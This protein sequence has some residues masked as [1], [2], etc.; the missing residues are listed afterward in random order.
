MNDMAGNFLLEVALRS[1]IMF[2]TLL[3]VLKF[4]GKRGIKQLSIFELVIII[5]LGSAAGDPM[6]Y[7][8]VGI[9]HG[10][11]VLLVVLLLYR[12]LTWITGKSPRLERLLEGDPECLLQD[13]KLTEQQFAHDNL[14]RDE[15]FSVL[16]V[17]GVEHLG[18]VREAYLETSGDISVFFYPD[19]QVKPGL[20]ILPHALKHT[21]TLIS[22]ASQY[23]CCRCGEVT[24]LAF[25]SH[26]CNTCNGN[27]WILPV[28]SKRIT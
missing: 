13:G 17:R 23:C 10:I 3:I 14:G 21:Q 18:Q 12:A 27:S 11:I 9:V 25:G 20:P 26:T 2:I 16:R 28:S 7:E 6:F 19:E 24:P 22:E 8:D 5:S 4:A 15:F 1:L